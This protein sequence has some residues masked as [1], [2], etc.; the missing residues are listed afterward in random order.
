L[1]QE[2]RQGVLRILTLDCATQTVLLLF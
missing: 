2:K 1:P